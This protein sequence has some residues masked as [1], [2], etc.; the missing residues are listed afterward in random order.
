MTKGTSTRTGP[1]TRY[2]LSGHYLSAG[3]YVMVVGK[4]W[5]SSWRLQVE[6]TSGGNT[7]RAYTGTQYLD[8]RLNAVTQD[9]YRDGCEVCASVWTYAGPVPGTISGGSLWSAA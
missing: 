9:E 6:F 7:Y 4:A 2:S 3:S 8:V 5:D 1:G